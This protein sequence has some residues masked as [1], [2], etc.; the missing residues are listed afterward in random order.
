M[1][2]AEVLKFPS[3]LLSRRESKGIR[4]ADLPSFALSP[5]FQRAASFVLLVSGDMLI[6]FS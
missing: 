4:L 3:R 1:F 6:I 5:W 2:L